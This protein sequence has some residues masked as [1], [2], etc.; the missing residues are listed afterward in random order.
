MKK[1]SIKGILLAVVF[2]AMGLTFSSCTKT[3]LIDST[4]TITEYVTITNDLW[5]D[6]REVGT[7]YYDYY[8]TS[9]D[10]E[11]LRNGDVNVYLLLASGGT[12]Y[13][14]PLPYV[15]AREFTDGTGGTVFRPVNL[16]FDIS[17][18]MITF[19]VSDLDEYITTPNELL[20]M[21]FRVVITK[22]VTY[23]IE[24]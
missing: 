7:M 4:Q 6:T 14:E 13:Q 16:R 3:A 24:Q 21:R 11:V 22:P 17:N 5:D 20:T 15:Y 9:I 1:T 8:C 23:A 12:E 18:N 19:M 10:S 2:A